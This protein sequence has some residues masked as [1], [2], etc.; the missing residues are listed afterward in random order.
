[1]NPHD[2]WRESEL[3][4]LFDDE[5][6]HDDTE[7]CLNAGRQALVDR[8]C[9]YADVRAV[10]QGSA[11]NSSHAF[12]QEFRTRVAQTQAA[13]M[14]QVV[15]PAQVEQPAANDGV[16]RW[17][18]VAGLAS[19]A[20]VVVL[21]WSV[22]G[23]KAEQPA[24]TIALVA[25]PSFA[26]PYAKVQG[27]ALPVQQAVAVAPVAMDVEAT[28]REVMLRDPA[29]DEFLRAHSAQAGAMAL[30]NTSGFMRNATYGRD[31]L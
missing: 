14:A 25:P 23:L 19:C 28:E 16:F 15:R 5:L 20:T 12:L 9:D 30:E 3:S 24:P 22:V 18:L 11:A 27:F 13:P 6:M 10:L 29:L 2:D 1:M 26:S 21:A 31:G 7:H 17:K 4:A 8:W